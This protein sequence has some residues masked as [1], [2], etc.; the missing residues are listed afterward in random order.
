MAEITF[1]A[2]FKGTIPIICTDKAGNTSASVTVGTNGI[3]IEDNAPE[4]AFKAE[5]AE[6]LPSGE[7]KNVSD[8][9]VTVADDKDNA[10]SG[11]IASVK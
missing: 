9:V 3:I 4:I 2:N 1:S 11:G 10:V 6:L 7:Y 5:N 8:I